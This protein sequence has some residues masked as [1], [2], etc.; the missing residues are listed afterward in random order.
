MCFR[1]QKQE[2]VAYSWIEKL[3][4]AL[5]MMTDQKY[6]GFLAQELTGKENQTFCWNALTLSQTATP[7]AKPN[8]NN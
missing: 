2:K 7:E 1:L 5:S 8:A 3:K 4:S 6:V